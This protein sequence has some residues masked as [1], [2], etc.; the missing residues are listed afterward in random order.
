MHDSSSKLEVIMGLNVLFGDGLGNGLR[1]TFL[2]LVREK[3]SK[4]VFK[5]WHDAMDEEQ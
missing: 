2:E 1:I 4:S 3:S 5:K